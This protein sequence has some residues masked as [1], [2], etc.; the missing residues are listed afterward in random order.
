MD[1]S[2]APAGFGVAALWTR[3]TCLV[4]TRRLVGL[5]LLRVHLYIEFL[6]I[7]MRKTL[8]TEG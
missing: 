4:L 8:K 3:R 5:F 7:G 6:Y 1:A 2:A